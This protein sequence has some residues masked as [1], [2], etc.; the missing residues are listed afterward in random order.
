VGKFQQTHGGTCL[1]L[2]QF[3][4][5]DNPAS[6]VRAVRFMSLEHG[7]TRYARGCRRD[8]CAGAEREYQRNRYRRRRGLPVD[9]SD[10]PAPALNPVGLPRNGPVVLAMQAPYCRGSKK[11]HASRRAAPP[12]PL[13]L[14][15][16]PWPP[17]GRAWLRWRWRWRPSWTT[18]SGPHSARSCTP[19]SGHFG[20]VVEADAPQRQ[21]CCGARDGSSRMPLGP[22]TSNCRDSMRAVSG[23]RV[24]GAPSGALRCLLKHQN[25][26]IKCWA[27]ADAYLYRSDAVQ[28]ERCYAE[29]GE[30][31]R[32]GASDHHTEAQ[33]IV[34]VVQVE[35]FTENSPN[36]ERTG[37]AKN[38]TD[39]R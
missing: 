24:A 10:H 27:Y 2:R 13:N 7:R 4:A 19:T 21:A 11:L 29:H 3:F 6:H 22:F 31:Y 15:P 12:S 26:E 32:Q 28:D 33:R 17:S 25:V 14:L 9:P 5:R 1:R 38:R 8:V 36:V 35:S 30:N 34:G 20:P 23:W 18:R 37:Q 16:G 39:A